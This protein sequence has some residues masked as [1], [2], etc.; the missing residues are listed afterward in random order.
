MDIVTVNAVLR[1]TQRNTL[2]NNTFKDNAMGL[3][4]QQN[5]V[6]NDQCYY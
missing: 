4:G 2:F 6:L 1:I 3:M 5:V